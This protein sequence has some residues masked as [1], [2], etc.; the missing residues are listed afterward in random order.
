MRNIFKIASLLFAA[1]M[2][3]ACEKPGPDTETAELRIVTDK[4]VIQ[5]NG[6]DAATMPIQKPAKVD[7]YVNEEMADALGINPASI[8]I[9]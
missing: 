2:L 4:D 9:N 1:V 3:F 5:A 7:L 6:T 8:T